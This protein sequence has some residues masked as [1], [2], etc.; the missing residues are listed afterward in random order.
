MFGI[1]AQ[2]IIILLIIGVFLFGKKLPEIGRYIGR[3]LSELKKGLS[4]IEEDLVNTPP[5]SS[6]A[7][8]EFPRPPQRGTTTAP[9]FQ[10]PEAVASQP[11][12]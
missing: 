4:G 2:E 7:G 11:T 6:P 8:S 3:G 5:S 9:K 12:A 10:A 1:G